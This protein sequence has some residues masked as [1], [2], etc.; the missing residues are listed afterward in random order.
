MAGGRVSLRWN[1][2][3]KNKKKGRGR[4]GGE[5]GSK[6]GVKE[7]STETAVFSERDMAATVGDISP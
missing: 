3:S 4:G 5:A 1:Q 7:T 2:A 6:K